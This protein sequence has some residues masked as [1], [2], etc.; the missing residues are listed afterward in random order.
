MTHPDVS[1]DTNVEA[2]DSDTSPPNVS[3]EA[4]IGTTVE[5]DVDDLTDPILPVNT[6][7][8]DDVLVTDDVQP[9][10]SDGM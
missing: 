6:S 10:R 5:A 7:S 3:D 4:D 9:Q 1:S 2:V 8:E